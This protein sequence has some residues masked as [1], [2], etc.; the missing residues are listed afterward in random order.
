[1][2]GHAP[3]MAFQR[4]AVGV[5]ERRGC[6]RYGAWVLG[7]GMLWSSGLSIPDDGQETRARYGSH[8]NLVLELGISRKEAATP[9][10][11]RLR[12]PPSPEPEA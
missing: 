3:H 6:S 12:W 2:R 4:P 1:M 9:A 11:I 5:P 7:G 8:A 10:S